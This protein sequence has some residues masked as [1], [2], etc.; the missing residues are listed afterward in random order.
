MSQPTFFEPYKGS[1]IGIIYIEVKDIT[2]E[3]K[4]GN[5]DDNNIIIYIKDL[6]EKT[7]QTRATSYGFCPIELPKD[8]TICC[9]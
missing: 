8:E 1:K 9:L 2:I 5:N 3:I 4:D 6:D 7:V